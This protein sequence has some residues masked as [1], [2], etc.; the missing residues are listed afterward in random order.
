M[1]M[2][3]NM[4]SPNLI[5]MNVCLFFFRI[6]FDGASTHRQQH[7]HT[8]NRSFACLLPS[9]RY[10]PYAG[11]R[12]TCFTFMPTINHTSHRRAMCRICFSVSI[13]WRCATAWS[14]RLFTIG[15]I[16]DSAITFKKSCAFVASTCGGKTN[17][18]KAKPF[19]CQIHV[20]CPSNVDRSHVSYLIFDFQPI[21]FP[22]I[23]LFVLS[24]FP[25]RF[26]FIFFPLYTLV[27]HIYL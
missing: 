23:F 9:S 20:H 22:I 10:S 5:I 16:D 21:F 17:C 6:R 18:T 1:N 26:F 19:T 15:W 4:P 11:C 27:L 25:C 3:S 7:H 13:G 12:I 2:N 8:T 14:I 24:S